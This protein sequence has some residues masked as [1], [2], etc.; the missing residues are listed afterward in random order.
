MSKSSVNKM[1]C[2]V[3]GCQWSGTSVGCF[4][5]K[6]HIWNY[7]LSE[8]MKT[9]HALTNTKLLLKGMNKILSST[10]TNQCGNCSDNNGNCSDNNGNCSDNNGNCSDNFTAFTYSGTEL[11]IPCHFRILNIIQDDMSTLLTSL[12]GLEE[13]AKKNKLIL[14][15]CKATISS[16]RI[17]KIMRAYYKIEIFKHII[18]S[19]KVVYKALE[20][21]QS[22]AVYQDALRLE[23]MMTRPNWTV[24]T[25]IPL[26]IKYRNHMLGG[27]TTSRI[28]IMITTSQGTVVVVELKA[29]NGGRDSLDKAGQQCK[30]YLR[31]LSNNNRPDINAGIVINFPDKRYKSV[32][33]KVVII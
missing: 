18:T 5:I 28:D 7:H 15:K 23:L 1:T 26:T 4:R 13:R 12:L 22:E 20:W 9:S 14:D 24:T 19:S 25:E 6:G 31:L 29:I 17:Y 21:G 10:P 27:A 8:Q 16:W 32:Q 11:I 2:P 30:R 3:I 33:S